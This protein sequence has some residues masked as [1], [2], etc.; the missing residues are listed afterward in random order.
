M[1]PKKTRQLLVGGTV[2]L[3]MAAGITACGDDDDDAADD[4]TSVTTVD[5]ATTDATDD[6]NGEEATGDDGP[7]LEVVAVDYAFEGLPDE[8]EAG[9]RLTLRNDAA[10]ELHELVAFR[11][12]DDEERSV[13]EIVQLPPE[14]MQ[15]VL[16]EP[17]TVILAPPESEQVAVPVGD[18][19][20]SEPG[21]YAL[22]CVIPTGAD[23]E[24]YM[25]A[26]ADSDGPPDV[27]GGPPHIAHGM[28]AEI[29]VE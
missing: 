2:V 21:R 26:A 19:T 1:H 8:V 11:L 24:E 5:D 18:G 27:A 15:G 3:A 28:Y 12:D 7:T 4:D 23:P 20:L 25:A 10:G 9:T 22:V 29:V 6:A 17:T 14:E 13:D 16:G